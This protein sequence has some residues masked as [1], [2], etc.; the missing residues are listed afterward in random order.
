MLRLFALVVCLLVVACHRTPRAREL[1]EDALAT[2]M[3][4]GA[5]RFLAA[6]SPA[7]R[8]RAR[9]DIGDAERLNWHFIPRDRRGIPIGELG[10]AQR[11]L[12]FGF[13]ATALGRRGLLKATAIMALEEV[14]RERELGAG[15]YV[16][17]PGAYYLSVFGEPS[18]TSTWGWRLE[19]HHLSLNLTLVDGHR[20]IA[21]PTFLGASPSPAVN[22]VLGREEALGFELVTDLDEAQ[23]RVARYT[24]TPP[25]DILLGPGVVFTE[26]PG[27]AASEMTAAQRAVLAALIDAAVECLPRELADRERAKLAGT[28]TSIR[29]TWAGGMT[30]GQPHYFRIAGPTF[31]YEFDNTQEHATHVHTGWHSRTDDFGIDS[32]REHVRIDHGGHS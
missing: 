8:D 12:A 3:S 18:T 20:A 23:R 17:D 4:D 26:L 11:A 27:L 30:P 24:A 6:L 19:G 16:R 13:L 15:P 14:L 5:R 7:Q 32:L 10:A 29:F 2:D 25:E 9:F 1:V 31:V 21:A 28:M 22:G